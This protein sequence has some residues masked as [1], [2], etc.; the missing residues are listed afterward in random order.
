MLISVAVFS[1]LAFFLNPHRAGG[2][3]FY[4]PPLKFFRE[5]PKKRQRAA[6]PFLYTNPFIQ[7]CPHMRKFQTRVVHFG[8]FSF[9]VICNVVQCTVF[10]EKATL[11]HYLGF[12]IFYGTRVPMKNRKDGSP[13]F[14]S[15][16]SLGVICNVVQCTVFFSEKGTLGHFLGVLTFLRDKGPLNEKL[17]R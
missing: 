2:G 11:G 15:V 8:H 10:S 7:C 1:K 14:L 5:Y 12:L 9:E 17:K 13:A 16:L 3:R 4:A 6:Q